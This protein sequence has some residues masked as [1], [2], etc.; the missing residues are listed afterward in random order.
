MQ[1]QE[2]AFAKILNKLHYFDFYLFVPYI[3]LCGLGIIMVYSASSINLSY[4]NLRINEYL[5]KQTLYVLM[6]LVLL[7]FFSL[8][9]VFRFLSKRKTVS[10]YLGIVLLG[11]L[12]ALLFG[13][14]VN[15]ARGWINLG[16]IS[17][18][19]AE[20]CKLGFV[21]F[22]ARYLVIHSNLVADNGWLRPQRTLRGAGYIILVG[23]LL[24][25]ILASPDLG[26][27]AINF[28]IIF[29]MITACGTQ[30]KYFRN[31]W[32]GLTALIA[33][34]AAGIWAVGGNSYWRLRFVAVTNPFN[35]SSSVGKQLVNSYYALSNGGLFGVGL[36]NSVQK[37]GYLPEPYTDFILSII[38]EELG[39]IGAALVVGLLAFLVGRIFVIGIRCHSLYSALICYGVGTFIA[40]ESFFNIGGVVGFLPITGVTLPFISYGGSSMLVL[41]IAVGLVMNIASAQRRHKEFEL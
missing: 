26:G 4:A 8:A 7:L 13:A 5:I 32:L 25:T 6:G 34:F 15:G 33:A 11:Q 12:F 35:Y 31:M 38:A 24:L 40:V 29:V 27:T 2:S 21:L 17:I 18:Q 36:G 30:M 41:S 9:N 37:R 23:V 3:L 14:R 19:P 16:F 22:F 39:A 10:W 28:M 20:F 1:Q